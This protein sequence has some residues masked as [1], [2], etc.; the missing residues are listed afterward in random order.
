MSKG[1]TIGSFM[2]PRFFAHLLLVACLVLSTSAMAF[3]DINDLS[4]DHADSAWSV[5]SDSHD[6]KHAHH[7]HGHFV[8]DVISDTSTRFS[9]LPGPRQ[10]DLKSVVF[11]LSYPPLNPPPNA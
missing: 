1:F 7:C 10:A 6:D 4:L 8:G 9:S 5:A 3:C 11:R 2:K